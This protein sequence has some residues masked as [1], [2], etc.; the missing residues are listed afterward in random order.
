MSSVKNGSLGPQRISVLELV[1]LIFLTR[2]SG[3]GYF[4]NDPKGVSQEI[5]SKCKLLGVSRDR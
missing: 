3:P 4:E 2:S 1:K 5:F